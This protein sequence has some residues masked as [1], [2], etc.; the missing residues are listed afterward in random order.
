MRYDVMLTTKNALHR[1][2]FADITQHEQ[3]VSVANARLIVLPT[4]PSHRK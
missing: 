4:L 2:K 3:E 1:G